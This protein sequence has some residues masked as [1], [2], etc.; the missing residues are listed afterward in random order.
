MNAWLPMSAGELQPVDGAT[1]P[2]V[3]TRWTKVVGVSLSPP[4]GPSSIPTFTSRSQATAPRATKAESVKILSA[5]AQTLLVS[6]E[7]CHV[8]RIAPGAT[9][10]GPASG[11]CGF[12]L[13]KWVV[14]AP[15][16]SS[17]S[18]AC[19]VTSTYATPEPEGRQ[20]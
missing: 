3:F 9:T 4:V 12:G 15:P 20:T 10:P 2:D 19:G 18:V 8:A 13:K 11:S 1:P 17:N 16:S 6:R 7:C 5:L 14:R